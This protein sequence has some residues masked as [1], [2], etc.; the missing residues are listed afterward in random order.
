M[1]EDERIGD[2]R[3]SLV[4]EYDFDFSRRTGENAQSKRWLIMAD[5]EYSSRPMQRKCLGLIDRRKIGV[6][7]CVWY[8][9]VA[10]DRFGFA[11]EVGLKPGLE[12]FMQQVP[13][14]KFR[15]AS[16]VK[17]SGSG[18]GTGTAM[19]QVFFPTDRL[20]D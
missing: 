9:V 6:V 19:R 8:A 10:G 7:Q 5:V 11:S 18:T 2:K 12:Y 3:L 13:W 20:F 16:T 14:V 15:A 1:R 17:D 4:A